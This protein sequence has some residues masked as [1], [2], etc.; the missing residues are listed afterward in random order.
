MHNVIAWSSRSGVQMLPPALARDAR[1]FFTG[2][3]LLLMLSS[4]HAT[5]GLAKKPSQR[6]AKAQSTNSDN[7][8]YSNAYNM[9]IATSVSQPLFTTPVGFHDAPVFRRNQRV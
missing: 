1:G 2:L 3:L 6:N 5:C 8:A 4:Y 9:P 7:C